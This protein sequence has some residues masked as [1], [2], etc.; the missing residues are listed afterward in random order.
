MHCELNCVGP[1]TKKNSYNFKEMDSLL[2]LAYALFK[3]IGFFINPF[4]A[5]IN[6]LCYRSIKIPPIQNELLKMPVIELA[7][8]IRNKEVSVSNINQKDNRL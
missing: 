1:F 2:Q 4:L 7:A 3:I 5:I 8:K 6:Y